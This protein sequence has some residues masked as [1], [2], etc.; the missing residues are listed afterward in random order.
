MGLVV[1]I[2]CCDSICWE[3]R[4]H[5]NIYIYHEC[6]VVMMPLNVIPGYMNCL[7]VIIT[8]DA[9]LMAWTSYEHVVG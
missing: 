8:C 1:R 5:M 2:T 6:K 3:Q 4:C 7:E 9:A